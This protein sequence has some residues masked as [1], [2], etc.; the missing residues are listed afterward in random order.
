MQRLFLAGLTTMVL[1][2]GVAA[3][4][5]DYPQQTYR[6]TYP[7]YRFTLQTGQALTVKDIESGRPRPNLRRLYRGEDI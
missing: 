6:S 4:V 7:D 5:N 1:S 3:Q 2:G